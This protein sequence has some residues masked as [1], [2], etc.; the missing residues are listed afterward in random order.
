MGSIGSPIGG[1]ITG[2]ELVKSLGLI[3]YMLNLSGSYMHFCEICL[4]ADRPIDNISGKKPV[5]YF[6]RIMVNNTCIVVF[7]NSY[8][9]KAI[10]LFNNDLVSGGS[11]GGPPRPPPIGLA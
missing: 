11:K 3:C 7:V 10:T 2:L 8:H 5:K 4:G 1:D 6:N 9:R